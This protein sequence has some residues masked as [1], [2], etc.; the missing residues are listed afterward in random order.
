MCV[1]VYVCVCVCVF[2]CVCVCVCV[3]VCVCVCA[4]VSACVCVRVC[5]HLSG[6]SRCYLRT[7]YGTVLTLFFVR[8]GVS[9][10]TT[11][12]C[13]YVYEHTE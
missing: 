13:S 3:S 10:E 4:C 2:V 8:D 11:L 7:H 9:G 6:G 1:C 5:V 12:V